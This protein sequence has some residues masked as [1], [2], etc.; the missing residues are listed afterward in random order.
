MNSSEKCCHRNVLP[1]VNQTLAVQFTPKTP[2][3]AEILS[4][5]DM[6]TNECILE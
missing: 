5:T 4:A 6:L 2:T 1:V 3:F